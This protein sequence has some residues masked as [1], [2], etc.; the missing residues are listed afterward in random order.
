[1]FCIDGVNSMTGNCS[2]L[3]EYIRICR[4]YETLLYIDD[5]HGFGVIG[6]DP[7]DSMPYGRKGNS[8][9]RYFGESYDDLVLVRA[10]QS[11]TRRSW[12]SSPSRPR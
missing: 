8:I 11:R 1:M 7:T 6:E 4:E 3:P 10:S 9:V 5:A 2:P 12:R